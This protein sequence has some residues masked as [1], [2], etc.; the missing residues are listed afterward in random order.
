MNLFLITV[1]VICIIAGA[2]VWWLAKETLEDKLVPW[3]CGAWRSHDL[4]YIQAFLAGLVG[5]WMIITGL[6]W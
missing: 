4:A 6:I 3:G 1:G 5:M 2:Y